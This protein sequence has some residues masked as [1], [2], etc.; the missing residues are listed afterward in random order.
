[1]ALFMAF[2]LVSTNLPDFLGFA[3]RFSSELQKN[4][5]ESQAESQAENQVILTLTAPQSTVSMGEVGR[6]TSCRHRIQ[7]SLRQRLPLR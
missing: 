1:M 6:A 3:E 2:V 4:K 5:E 7:R